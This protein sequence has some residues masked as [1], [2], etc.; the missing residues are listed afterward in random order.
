MPISEEE[1]KRRL[2]LCRVLVEILRPTH[3]DVGTTANER[4]VAYAVGISTFGPHLM[5]LNKIAEA[6]G[7]PRSTV[8][9]VLHRLCKR[10]WVYKTADGNYIITDLLQRLSE[11]G[12][13][14]TLKYRAIKTAADDLVALGFGG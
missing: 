8:R 1:R 13:L 7:L 14:L 5:G 10:E 4:L 2:I 9:A 11:E 6:T 12:L 3:I